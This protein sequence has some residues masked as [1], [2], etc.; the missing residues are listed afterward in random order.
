MKIDDP[1]THIPLSRLPLVDDYDVKSLNDSD[2]KSLTQP[3]KSIKVNEREGIPFGGFCSTLHR[4]ESAGCSGTF[5]VR[6]KIKSSAL[7]SLEMMF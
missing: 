3:I 1:S 2:R 7:K 5:N 4:D 6:R